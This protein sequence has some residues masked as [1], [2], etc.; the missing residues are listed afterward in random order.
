MK[1]LIIG[2]RFN[3]LARLST[4]VCEWFSTYFIDLRYMLIV[5]LLEYF[6]IGLWS[7]DDINRICRC[8]NTG[9]YHI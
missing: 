9:P 8:N 2:N 7:S 5:V 4:V 6:F 1:I 3:V